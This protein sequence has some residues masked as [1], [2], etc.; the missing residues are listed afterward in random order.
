MCRR[1]VNHACWGRDF[2]AGGTVDDG[3][4]SSVVVVEGLEGLVAV[5]NVDAVERLLSSRKERTGGQ[6]RHLDHGGNVGA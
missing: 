1:C 5:F 6:K 4:G 2:G 3:L